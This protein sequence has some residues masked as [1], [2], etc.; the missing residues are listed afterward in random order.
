[1]H[2]APAESSPPNAARPAWVRELVSRSLK[3][4]WL[5]LLGTTV[6]TWLFFIGYFHVLRNPAYEVTVMPLT[7][8]DRLVGFAPGALAAYV[9]LWFYVGIAPG[10][11]A[12]FRELV[13]YGLWVAGLCLSGLA[14]FHFWP[15][16]VP[17]HALDLSGY[18][19][20]AILQGM[21]AAAN[22]CPSM[23]VASAVFSAL[24][25]DHL[26]REIAAAPPVRAANWCWFALIAYSTIAVKQHVFLDV[27][28]G[29]ALGTAF[30]LPA[31]RCR[32]MLFR[33]VPGR[34]PPGAQGASPSPR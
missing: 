14:M 2:D 18:P 31:I 17:P 21:D 25:L 23:H 28:A 30:A 8:I 1:M 9:S 5:K 4:L 20:F 3:L 16:A 33:D 13:A 19:G 15:T 34:T 22:A 10:L 29:L 24:W 7:P 12:S 32:W 27:L 26:L 6:F 11:L